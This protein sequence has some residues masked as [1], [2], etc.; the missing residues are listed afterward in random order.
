VPPTFKLVLFT[1]HKPRILGADEAIWR[2][3]RLI[4]FDYRVPDDKK[5]RTLESALWESEATGI[6]R[7]LVERC[8]QWATAGLRIVK[9]SARPR[10]RTATTKM[11]STVSWRSAAKWSRG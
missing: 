4:P 2:R 1:N 11:L 6:L 3:A 10:L 8:A 5:D 9:L 7:W